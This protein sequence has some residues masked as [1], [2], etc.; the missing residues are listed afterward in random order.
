MEIFA[1]PVAGFVLPIETWAIIGCRMYEKSFKH[2]NP[3]ATQKVAKQTR[4]VRPTGYYPHS[5]K[6]RTEGSIRKSRTSDNERD[7]E[8]DRKKGG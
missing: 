3:N 2:G 7:R 5:P 8:K 4:T 6:H 1:K